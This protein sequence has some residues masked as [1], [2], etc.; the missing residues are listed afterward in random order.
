VRAS[1]LIAVGLLSA[2]I[3]ASGCVPGSAQR[4][5][6]D[7]AEPALTPAVAPTAEPL[8]GYELPLDVATL[9][10][11]MGDPSSIERPSA[12][13]PSPWGQWLVWDRPDGTRFRALAG[14]YSPDST[15]STA[16][17]SYIEL[18]ASPQLESGT[19]VATPTI[20]GFTLNG[21]DI[22]EVDEAL[23]ES[24]PSMMHDRPELDPD[25]VYHASILYEQD[26]LYTYFFF[27]DV[28]MLVGVGQ[29]VFYMDGAD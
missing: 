14:D 17:V 5:S 10:A 19:T 15:D 8:E 9:E 23:P 2:I 4:T 11:D 18:R 22:R 27:D 7:P 1:K 28:G 16:G 3:L 12:D 26:G 29:A 24:T 13:D 21:T 6:S 25:D 20:H